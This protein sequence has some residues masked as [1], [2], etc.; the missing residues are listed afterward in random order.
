MRWSNKRISRN[1]VIGMTKRIWI[2]EQEIAENDKKLCAIAGND[3][4]SC[5]NCSRSSTTVVNLLCTIPF[6]KKAETSAA[7]KAKIENV[8][9]KI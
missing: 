8:I 5:S 4:A 7:H 3:K 9:N 2:K 1:I 6:I